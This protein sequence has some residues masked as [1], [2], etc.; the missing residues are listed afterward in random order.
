MLKTCAGLHVVAQTPFRADGAVDFDSIDT[1]S[2]FY[3]RHGAQGLLVLG[4]SGEAQMLTPDEAVAVAARFVAASGDRRIVAGVSSPS[5][6]VL[7]SV[8]RDVM[9]E[10]ADG[11]MICPPGHVRT[12]E[13]IIGYFGAVFDRIGDVPVVLQDFPAASGVK[14]SVPL[15][16]RLLERFPAIEV[17]KEED[18]PSPPKIGRL[19]AE[20]PRPVRILTGNNGMYLPQELERGADGPMAGFSYPEML[21]GVYDLMQRDDR[22]GAHDLFNRYL[23]LLRYEAQGKW[24][25]AIR[26]EMMRR[27]GALDCA[28][29]RQ[30]A[31]ALGEADLAELDFLVGRMD[32]PD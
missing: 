8:T 12:D 19:R 27:R 28:I 21:S 6:A 4:V 30:P 17:I 11:V 1:L 25:I 23:P 3:Y 13:E 9:S 29:L 2:A 20:M 24:G 22:A 5:L 15:I 7:E 18:F 26:K 16:G 14:M 31:P 10:G 32:L